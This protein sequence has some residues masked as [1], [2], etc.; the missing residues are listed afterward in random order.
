LRAMI[1]LMGTLVELSKEDLLDSI[2]Y[3]SGVSGSTWCMS[4]VYEDVNWSKN[5]TECEQRLNERLNFPAYPQPGTWEKIKHALEGGV[6]SLTVLWSYLVGNHMIKAI[7]ENSLANHKEAC[8]HGVNPYPIYAAVEKGNIVKDNKTAPG[9]WFEFTPHD[10][11]FPDFGAF[12]KTEDIGSKFEKGNLETTKAQQ[13]ICYLQGLWGSALANENDIKLYI[14]D[15]IFSWFKGHDDT[16]VMA[17]A[18]CSPSITMQ[19]DVP[20]MCVA[21]PAECSCECCVA[22]HD[23]MALSVEELSSEAGQAAL[24]KLEMLLQE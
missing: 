9:T 3:L 19:D 6:Y 14:Q 5:V 12:V 17:A 22:A 15:Y 4:S 2:M 18:P 11:G 23:L 7:N 1:A 24:M 10:A 8:E 20:E 21:A 13:T 16:P